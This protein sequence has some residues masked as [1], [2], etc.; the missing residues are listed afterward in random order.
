MSPQTHQLN[1]SCFYYML[2]ITSGIIISGW[3]VACPL[4]HLDTFRG[5]AV[6]L[7]SLIYLTCV[8]IFFFFCDQLTTCGYGKAFGFAALQKMWEKKSKGNNISAF[9]HLP[10]PQTFVSCSGIAHRMCVYVR[11]CQYKTESYTVPRESV[12]RK[13]GPHG[14]D[15]GKLC[16][17]T[18]ACSLS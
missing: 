16:L 12:K 1:K 10:P 13:D 7:R 5:R 6:T 2:T 15:K 18:F 8:Y 14:S 9:E 3:F 4:F 17:A 11:H